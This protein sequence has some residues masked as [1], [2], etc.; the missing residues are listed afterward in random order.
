MPGRRCRRQHS[1]SAGHEVLTQLVSVHGA[2]RHLRS[3]NGPKFVARPVPKWLTEAHISTA[4][5]DP[6]KPWQ[7]GT[8]ESFNG[9]FRDECL[10]LEWFGSRAYARIV[11]EAWRRPYNAERP[12]S[13]LGQRTPA[14]CIK[15]I[16]T[17]P[18]RAIFQVLNGPKK[19]SRTGVPPNVLFPRDRVRFRYKPQ[20]VQRQPEVWASSR[21][22]CRE[23]SCESGRAR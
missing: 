10:S 1:L 15:S 13:S 7:N 16:S 17:S 19:A 11:I 12:H 8:G 2:P 14:E 4:Y 22:V 3:D 20:S 23:W 9:K 6:G 5:M 18:T 21:G